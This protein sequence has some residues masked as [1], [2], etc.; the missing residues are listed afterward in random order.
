LFDF[1]PDCALSIST[2]M[3]TTKTRRCKSS[4]L[5][6]QKAPQE[7]EFDDDCDTGKDSGSILK[8]DPGSDQDLAE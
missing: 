4:I 3:T 8:T 7:G 2:T 1:H 6:K 5:W